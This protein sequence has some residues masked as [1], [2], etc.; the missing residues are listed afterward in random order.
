[1]PGNGQVSIEAVAGAVVIMIALV[2]VMLQT[3]YRQ[4]QID[5]VNKSGLQQSDCVRLTSAIELVQGTE[6]NAGIETNI[7]YDANIAGNFI[8]FRDY[9]CEHR[10]NPFTASVSAGKIA[11]TKVNGVVTAQNT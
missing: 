2:A 6:E 1:M 3:G 10:G 7:S 4:Q 8:N 9:Y 11:I 5:F